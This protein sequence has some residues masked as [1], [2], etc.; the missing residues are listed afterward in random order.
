M[1]AVKAICGDTPIIRKLTFSQ[2]TVTE[3]QM[4]NSSLNERSLPVFIM[5]QQLFI[6]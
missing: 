1:S 4:K 5:G 3:P 2:T 6:C